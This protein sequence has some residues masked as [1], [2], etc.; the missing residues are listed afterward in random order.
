[1][2][3]LVDGVRNKLISNPTIIETYR[4]KSTDIKPS[5]TAEHNGSVYYEMDTQD[6]FMFDGDTLTWLLQ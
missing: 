6:V 3:S 4:G 5:F 1:M 2:V